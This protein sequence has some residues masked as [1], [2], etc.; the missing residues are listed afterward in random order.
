MITYHAIGENVRLRLLLVDGAGAGI[1]GAT[2]TVAICRRSDGKFWD[3]SAWQSS[4]SNLSLIEQDPGALPGSYYLD[5]DQTAAGGSSEEYLVRYNCAAPVSLDE[6][7]HVF[8]PYATS[9]N[10]E[11]RIASSMSDDGISFQIAL[12]VEEGGLRVNNYDS[13]ASQIYDASGN[14]VVDLGADLSGTPQGVFTFQTDVAAIVRNRP[15]VLAVQATRGLV[16]D[17]FN[18]GFVRV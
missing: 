1:T 18:I 17:P 15:Y 6:E 8:R 13:V 12:W 14:L 4:V 7:Q 10:P 5:F 2:P 16:T 3:G 11:R 9:L